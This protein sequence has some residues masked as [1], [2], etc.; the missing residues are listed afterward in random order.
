MKKGLNL[1]LFITTLC[2]S[3][4]A[5]LLNL[6]KHQNKIEQCFFTPDDNITNLLVELIKEEKESIKVAMYYLS[7]VKII[8]E[9]VE[10]KKR[11][12]KVEVIIDNGC[13]T[14]INISNLH[15]LVDCGIT[16]N[17]FGKKVERGPMPLMH[18][19]YFIF[20]KNL[21]NKTILTT[22]SFNC[23]YSAQARNKENLIITESLHLIE[24]YKQN[25]DKLKLQVKDFTKKKVYYKWLNKKQNAGKL[26]LW[27]FS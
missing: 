18:N 9:L 6:I 14:K 10:A 27:K 20:S 24:Q 25:F 4:N 7:E 1:L 19:K 21:E 2:Y 17:V 16:L 12:I 3:Q 13:I 26:F 15:K 23:T 8:K 11:N 22:G 5:Q